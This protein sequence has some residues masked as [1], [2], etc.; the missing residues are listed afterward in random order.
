MPESQPKPNPVLDLICPECGQ[1]CNELWRELGLEN[2]AACP[3]CNYLWGTSNMH[4]WL[5]REQERFAEL[6]REIG[7][8]LGEHGSGPI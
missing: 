6:R 3:R 1:E 2:D 7:P 8:M 4:A 5:H